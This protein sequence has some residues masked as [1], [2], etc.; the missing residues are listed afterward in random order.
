M[1]AWLAAAAI[2]SGPLF[3]AATLGGRVSDA[4][5]ADDSASRIVKRHASRVGLE[6]ASFS[7]HR[8]RSG[9]L[10]SA[11]ESGANV[12]KLAVVSRH[13]SLDTLRGYVRHFRT[14][15][16]FAAWFGLTPLQKSTGGK[17][18]LGAVSKRGERTIRRLLILGASAVIRQACLRGAPAGSWLAQM[19][20]R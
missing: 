19:L 3:R 9:F 6:V 18:K 12:F 11:A 10:I 13:R 2:S 1:H 8:L 5:V 7:G 17:Q 20:P 14:G 15:R 16:D 4:A